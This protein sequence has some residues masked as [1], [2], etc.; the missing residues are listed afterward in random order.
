MA[1]NGIADASDAAIPMDNVQLP[2]SHGAYSTYS[3]TSGCTTPSHL[4][5]SLASGKG[6]GAMERRGL[7]RCP[8]I[9]K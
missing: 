3:P 1:L 6:G 7:Y 2:Y 5:A 9:V 8:L 4:Y